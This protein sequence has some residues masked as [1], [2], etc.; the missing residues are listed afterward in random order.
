M[1]NSKRH[2]RLLYTNVKNGYRR[3]MEGKVS[4]VNL[5]ISIPK[6]TNTIAERGMR[7]YVHCIRHNAEISKKLFYGL[8][9]EECYKHELTFLKRHWIR[10]YSR[11][12]DANVKSG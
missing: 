9:R 5:Y 8:L 1:L 6:L 11:N 10:R 3:I 4:N 12:K 2:K 7:L